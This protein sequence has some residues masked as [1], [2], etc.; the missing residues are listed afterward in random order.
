MSAPDEK[1][2]RSFNSNEALQKIENIQLQGIV[3]ARMS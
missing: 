3:A 2:L 1:R